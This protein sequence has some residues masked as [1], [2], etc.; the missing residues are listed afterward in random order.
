MFQL[1]RGAVIEP[2]AVTRKAFGS[3]RN[4]F[5]ENTLCVPISADGILRESPSA[6]ANFKVYIYI[7]YIHT[8][9]MCT[10]HLTQDLHTISYP[11]PFWGTPIGT[12]HIT[13]AR[14]ANVGSKDDSKA[15]V[16][17]RNVRN[18]QCFAMCKLRC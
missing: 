15:L 2:D 17:E 11:Q 12:P 5:S 3:R 8:V 13:A 9:Y 1:A 18:E 10:I 14:F 4:S 7:Y 6:V 16:D